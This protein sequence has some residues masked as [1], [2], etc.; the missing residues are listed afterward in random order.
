MF[1]P[2]PTESQRLTNIGPPRSP[3]SANEGSRKLQVVMILWMEEIKWIFSQANR[4]WDAPQ[5]WVM[6]F[7]VSGLL[8]FQAKGET[9]CEIRY[10]NRAP[11]SAARAGTRQ[12]RL[13]R[14]SI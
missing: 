4:V 12:R 6:V 9:N 10:F 8:P 13:G 7:A 14:A 3:P 2:D 1:P 11:T 5:R